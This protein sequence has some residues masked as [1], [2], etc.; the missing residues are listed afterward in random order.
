MKLHFDRWWENGL[1]FKNASDEIH[2]NFLASKYDLK[3]HS[4]A[5]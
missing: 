2:Q 3:Y 5:S 1:V 4:D